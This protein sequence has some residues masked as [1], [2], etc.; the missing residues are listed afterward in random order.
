MVEHDCCRYLSWALDTNQEERDKGKTVEVG[1]AY[2]ET[3]KKHF[4]ILDA[5]GHKSFVPNMIGGASQADLAVLLLP[6]ELWILQSH[7]GPIGLG[8]PPCLGNFCKER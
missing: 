3:E 4:T 1:R 8:G 5:P 7:H 6:P 2:F